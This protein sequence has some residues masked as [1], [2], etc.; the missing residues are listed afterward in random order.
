VVT[1]ATAAAAAASQRKDNRSEVNVAAVGAVAVDT[2]STTAATPPRN[3]D[4]AT[5]R[6]RALRLRSRKI[7]PILV[8]QWKKMKRARMRRRM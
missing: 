3:T 8:W 1:A 6:R 7:H 4:P 5:A 2:I